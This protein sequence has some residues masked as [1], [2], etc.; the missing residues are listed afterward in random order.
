MSRWAKNI[1]IGLFILFLG[2]LCTWFIDHT[3]AQKEPEK[4]TNKG[5]VKEFSTGKMEKDTTR[6]YRPIFEKQ[7]R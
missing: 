2:S 4:V 6:N 1:S 7:R 3:I 5:A